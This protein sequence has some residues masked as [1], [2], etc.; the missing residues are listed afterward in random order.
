VGSGNWGSGN[1]GSGGGGKMRKAISQQLYHENEV[2][3][4]IQF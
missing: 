2:K 4:K 3:K 1:G